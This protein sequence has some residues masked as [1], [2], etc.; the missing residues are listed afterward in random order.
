VE[1]DAALL[2]QVWTN[3]VSNAVK[4]SGRAECPRVC[5]SGERIL[6]E[7]VFCV[8]DNGVGFDPAESQRLFTA[9]QRLSTAR[10]FG[11]SGVG[12]AIVKRIVER[13][14]GRAWA[15]GEPGHGARFYFSLPT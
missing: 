13:H 9:F 5:V 4:Y 7:A 1:G 14:G 15:T 12:L 8:H 3:L 6:G 10:D 11:G 2:R